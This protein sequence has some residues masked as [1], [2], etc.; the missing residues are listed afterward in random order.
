MEKPAKKVLLISANVGAGHGQV[1]RAIVQGL[2]DV[3]GIEVKHVDALQY[4]YS[5][6]RRGYHGGFVLGMTTLPWVYGLGF[7]TSNRFDSASLGPTERMRLALER[8]CLR[9]L[10]KFIVQEQPDLIINTHFISPPIVAALVRRGKIRSPQMVIVTDNEVHRWWYCPGVDRFFVPSDADRQRFVHWGVPEDKIVIA[11]IPIHEKWTQPVDRAKVLADWRLPADKPI[12]TLTGGTEFTVG[13]IERIAAG[14]L[15][16][17]PD[18][19][20]VVLAGRNKELLE[21]L[22]VMAA[23]ERRLMPVS[24]TDRVN[25]LVAVSSLM[26]TKPGGVTTT[27]CSA[28]GTPMILLKPVPGQEA[29]N[30]DYFAAHGAAVITKNA[31]Q[32]IGEVARLLGDRVALEEM[33]RNVR[34]LYRP[35]TQIVV[36]AIC[37]QVS[38]SPPPR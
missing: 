34:S 15:H 6:F 16:A 33:S 37:R 32:A 4:A 13:P 31:E 7:L 28:K 17:C 9:P 21:R 26:V 36:E 19:H 35:G 14:I 5:F 20:V 1:A 29:C 11:G 2:R 22:G 27:E 30:A 23:A 38:S 8:F 25:E 3:A 10:A 12:V 24:F 18:A